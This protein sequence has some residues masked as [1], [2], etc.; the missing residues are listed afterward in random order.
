MKRVEKNEIYSKFL[1]KVWKIYLFICNDPFAKLLRPKI[2][3]ESSVNFK[4]C[5]ITTVYS[6]EK[7][8][9]IKSE[10]QLHTTV[11]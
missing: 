6:S 11:M 2:R 9:A 5:S 10:A 1:K 7:L 4:H 8:V 3:I